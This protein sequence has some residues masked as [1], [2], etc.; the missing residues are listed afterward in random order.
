MT[1]GFLPG[2]ELVPSSADKTL[3]QVKH[4]IPRIQRVRV[5]DLENRDERLLDEAELRMQVSA[6]SDMVRSPFLTRTA[7]LAR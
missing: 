4:V 6:H 1:P 7:C 2:D 5:L 3:Y